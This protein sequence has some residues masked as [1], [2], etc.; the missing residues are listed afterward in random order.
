[1]RE[2][3]FSGASWP[4][5]IGAHKNKMITNLRER[6]VQRVGKWIDLN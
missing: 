1:M 4:I 6:E 5:L 2:W 3:V